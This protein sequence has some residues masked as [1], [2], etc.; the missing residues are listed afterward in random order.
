MKNSGF[1]SALLITALAILWIHFNVQIVFD[2]S[3]DAFMTNMGVGQFNPF[4]LMDI[5][6]LGFVG[7]SYVYRYFQDLFM[8]INVF[9]TIHLALNTFALFYALIS[10]YSWRAIKFN[11]PLRVMV[12]LLLCV[13][14][15]ESI[16]FISHTRY[17]AAIAGFAIINLVWNTRSRRA[18]FIHTLLFAIA[19]LTRPESGLG[20]ALFVSIAVIVTNSLSIGVLKRTAIPLL[21]VVGFALVFNIHH[22]FT[23]RFDIKIEPDVEYA[24]STQRIKP[25]GELS[26]YED[27]L[28][29]AMTEQAMFIDTQFVSSS[30]LKSLLHDQF[31]LDLSKVNTSVSRIAS[32]YLYYRSLTFFILGVVLMMLFAGRSKSILVFLAFHLIVFSVLTYLDYNVKVENRHF[33]PIMQ[34]AV[35]LS[36]FISFRH[37]L[38]LSQKHRILTWLL[39]IVMLV[40]EGIDLRNAKENVN[41]VAQDVACLTET[42][43]EFEQNVQ[44]QIVAVNVASFHLFDRVYS[45]S[46]EVYK[47]NTYIMYD[48]SN[49]AVAPQNM[50]YLDELCGCDS[51][52]PVAFYNWAKDQGVIFLNTERR[53]NLSLAYLNFKS[54][55]TWKFTQPDKFKGLLKK[56]CLQQTVYADLIV[57]RIEN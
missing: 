42:M 22:A 19:F 5:H 54:D 29:F 51:E 55:T 47:Q 12:T 1:W 57:S 44:N 23:D 37:H 24:I 43:Q 25:I 14:F 38:I 16:S 6:Y 15:V 3:Y 20:G 2:D 34:I 13:L 32:N 17:A 48:L 39:S 7:L 56:E 45:L 4:A 27:S 50:R 18:F 33:L 52:N 8:H 28:K 21:M 9:G 26:S 40:L 49:Y 41:L 11:F 53:E 30:Y 10:I 35:V 36:S 31:E 46:N